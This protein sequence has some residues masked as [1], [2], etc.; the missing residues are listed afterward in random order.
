M[1]RENNLLDL[2]SL[3]AGKA[4]LV[5]VVYFLF[6]LLGYLF[7]SPVSQL[8]IIWPQ[9]G[10]AI[11]AVLVVGFEALPG[12]FI[13]SFAIAAATGVSA[14]LSALVALGSTLAAAF[15]AYFLLI[16]NNFSYMLENISSILKLLLLGVIFSPM[17]AA[18]ISLLGMFLVGMTVGDDFPMLWGNRWLRDALGA[19]VF[20]PFL[21]VWLGNDLPRFDKRNLLEGSAIILIGLALECLIFFGN[22]NPA[23][24]A[25]ITFF[26]IPIIIWASFRLKI[27]GL[28]SANLLI[29]AYFLWGSAHNIGALFQNSIL[30][31]PTFLIVLA[32]MWATSLILSASLAKYAKAQKSLSD[33]SNHDILTGLYNRLFFET[34][35]KRLENS[36]QFPI[37]II[38]TDLDNLKRV[39]DAFGHRAGDQLLKNLANLFET[40]FR[41]ED[42]I[43]RIG[44]DEFVVLLPNTGEPEAR[45]IMERLNKQVNLYNKDHPDLPIGISIGVSTA[46]QGESLLGHLKIADN[47]MYEEKA[48]KKNEEPIPFFIPAD[49]RPK[50]D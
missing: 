37:S 47:L 6:S 5:A 41:H 45:I 49:R 28:A 34:E 27:H 14:E 4:T 39:N 3:Y 7:V 11:A 24:A 13:G 29:M 17:I 12:V 32:T 19:L 22:L 40:I 48:R 15:P 18:T 21:I 43:C 23:T 36:R 8:P 25:S 2:A 38:M 30:V 46:S 44:G 50:G 31:N 42:I 20:A 16:K 26:L 10:L 1:N 9:A 33:L 35:L